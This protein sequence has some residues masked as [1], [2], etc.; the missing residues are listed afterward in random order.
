[1]HDRGLQYTTIAAVKSVLSGMLHTPGAIPGVI[2]ISSHPLI[3]RLMKGIFHVRPPKPCYEFIW[4]TELVHNFLKNLNPSELTAYSEDSY[5]P[6]FAI[7]A[8]GEHN[9]PISIITNAA[10]PYYTHL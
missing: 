7:R 4:D 2:S 10:Y 5:P 9:T 6:D 8:K 1:M 3:I